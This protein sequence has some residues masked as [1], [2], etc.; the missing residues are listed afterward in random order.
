MAARLLGSLG[1]LRP[2][3][4]CFTAVALEVLLGQAG[5]RAAAGWRML[6]LGFNKNT[7]QGTRA[8]HED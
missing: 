2:A 4:G 7:F 5:A 6:H 3:A 1:F 8:G